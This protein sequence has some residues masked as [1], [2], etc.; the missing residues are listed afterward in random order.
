MRD[1]EQSTEKLLWQALFENTNRQLD[2]N[3]RLKAILEPVV[4]ASS[5]SK[6]PGRTAKAL[7][8]IKDLIIEAESLQ[9]EGKAAFHQLFGVDVDS[10]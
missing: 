6:R 2:I 9:A 3:V 8:Q 5:K 7:D 1:I 4:T 10:E